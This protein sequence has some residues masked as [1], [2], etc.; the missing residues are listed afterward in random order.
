MHAYKVYLSSGVLQI[1]M[2][3]HT[4]A[5]TNTHLSGR[6]RL[7]PN[8][9]TGTQDISILKGDISQP[10]LCR[11][12]QPDHSDSQIC[13]PKSR[14]MRVWVA[15][16]WEYGKTSTRFELENTCPVIVG[17]PKTWEWICNLIC[18]ISVRCNLWSRKCVHLC[19]HYYLDSKQREVFTHSERAA[20]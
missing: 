13:S 11:K 17:S 20:V 15:T 19:I 2:H 16:Q 12:L 7:S 5:H 4:D 9:T 1:H 18:E 6:V 3:T 10:E 8:G 14:H